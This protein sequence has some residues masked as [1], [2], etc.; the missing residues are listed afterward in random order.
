M[1]EKSRSASFERR[2]VSVVG[3]GLVPCYTL[4]SLVNLTHLECGGEKLFVG[5]V[6]TH[7]TLERVQ[8]EC[9]L[10]DLHVRGAL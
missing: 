1:K 3:N 10:T 7:Q 4:K 5:T 9:P 2:G 6:V 8:Q